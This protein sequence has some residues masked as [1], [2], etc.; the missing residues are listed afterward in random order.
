MNFIN[1]EAHYEWERQDHWVP[2][3]SKSLHWVHSPCCCAVLKGQVVGRF[4]CSMSSQAIDVC[5][6]LAVSCPPTT[7][8]QGGY[9]EK[10]PPVMA[11]QRSWTSQTN[12]LTDSLWPIM[13][14]ILAFNFFLTYIKGTEMVLTNPLGC[15]MRLNLKVSVLLSVKCHKN[16]QYNGWLFFFNLK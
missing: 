10:S 2:V 7:L 11:L 14:H 4:S 3:G 13:G 8:H 1:E 12:F 5:L 15:W 6:G 9:S 16:V